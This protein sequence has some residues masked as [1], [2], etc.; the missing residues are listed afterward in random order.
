MTSRA[1]PAHRP[2][3]ER[4]VPFWPWLVVLCSA[5]ALGA[6]LV[7][8]YAFGLEPCALCVYQRWPYGIA[9]VLALA[10]ATRPP[11][12]PAR[13]GLLV[14]GGLVLWVGT[15][16]AAYHVGVE[17]GWWLDTLACGGIAIPEGDPQAVLDQLLSRDA[18]SCDVVT[19]SVFGVSMAGYNAMASLVLG[20]ATLWAARAGRRD[21][22]G[23]RIDG[24]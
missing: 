21:A 13:A 14:V 20:A 7:S 6:A 4:V 1:L 10:A 3:L 16:V 18:V 17:Q 9:I 12:G 19:F 24:E 15:L 22:T 2:V 11:A 23:S 5:I 8:Q